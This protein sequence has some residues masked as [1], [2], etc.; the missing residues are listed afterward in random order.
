MEDCASSGD[1]DADGLADCADPDCVD[2]CVE[3]CSAPGDEDADGLADCTDPDCT[4]VCAEDCGNETDDDADGMVD[5]ADPECDG[6]CVETDCSDGVDDDLDGR[7]D[8]EDSDCADAVGCTELCAAGSGDEDSDGWLDC[9]DDD[10]WG[11][12]ACGGLTV[13]VESGTLNKR[14]QS[15][16]QSSGYIAAGTSGRWTWRTTS[17]QFDLD[18]TATSVQ[19]RARLQRA[20]GSM[21]CAFGF[22]RAWFHED[23]ESSVRGPIIPLLERSGFWSSGAC[24]LSSAMMPSG[25]KSVAGGVLVYGDGT[26][27]SGWWYN[28]GLT[29]VDRVRGSSEQRD[30]RT[31]YRTTTW[32]QPLEPGQPMLLGAP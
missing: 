2:V 24:G 22:D 19:G 21:S 8:C 1:E 15:W 5:C 29:V 14:V 4:E 16:R 26:L 30:V 11:D 27:R 10:C 17:V 28:G 20:S 23:E 18:A 32:L 31:Q 9:A 25:V 6:V 7:V 13:W 3:D 12:P